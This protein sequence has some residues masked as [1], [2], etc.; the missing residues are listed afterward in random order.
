MKAVRANNPGSK[1]FRTTVLSTMPYAFGLAASIVYAG[2]PYPGWLEEWLLVSYGLLFLGELRAWWLPY[3]LGTTSA[4]VARYDSMF[5]YTHAF[6]PARHNI[7]PN[8]LHIVL[9]LTTVAILVIL[10]LQFLQTHATQAAVWL[11]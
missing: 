11:W 7:R 1:L 9:H 5:G 6:L 10:G 3:F 4:R 8:T 2:K